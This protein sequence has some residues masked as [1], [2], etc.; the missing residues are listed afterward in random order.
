MNNFGLHTCPHDLR[1]HTTSNFAAF[2]GA[3][4][5]TH[6]LLSN[7]LPPTDTVGLCREILP[8]AYRLPPAARCLL[9]PDSC[10]LIARRGREAGRGG[11]YSNGLSLLPRLPTSN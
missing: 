7:A 1:T 6:D 2:V 4:S 5:A 8:A 3:R 9:I 11:D 10:P